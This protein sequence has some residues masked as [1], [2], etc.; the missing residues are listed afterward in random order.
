MRYC[1][2][3][4][5]HTPNQRAEDCDIGHLLACCKARLEMIV[6][7]HPDNLTRER[8]RL[9]IKIREARI[10]EDVAKDGSRR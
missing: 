2:L 10:E 3:G 6:D 5:K 4:T 1:Q 7:H 9:E 8:A